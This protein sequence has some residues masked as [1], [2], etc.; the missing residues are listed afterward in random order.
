[1]QNIIDQALT[2][3]ATA[4]VSI[5][6]GIISYLG[7]KIIFFVKEK[8]KAI[9]EK[10]GIDKYNNEIQIAFNCWKIVDEKFRITPN[11]LATIQSKTD[12]FEQEILKKCPYLSKDQIDHLRQ[13]IAGTINQGKAFFTTS[14]Q[15]EQ[16]ETESQTQPTD[17]DIK[18]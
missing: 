1:M 11:L 5:L 17:T 3:L 15:A 8:T 13:S 4:L 12:M 16:I 14:S 9:Q 6:L 2:A 18:A 7:A 10:V